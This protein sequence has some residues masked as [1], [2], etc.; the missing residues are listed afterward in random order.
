[1]AQRRS[2][3]R[4]FTHTARLLSDRIRR[5]GETRGFAVTRLLTHWED[6]V[7]AEIASLATPLDVSYARRGASGG[8]GATL[9]LLTTGAKAPLLEMQ[10]PKIK[11]RVNACYGYN[12]IARVRITQT[13]P[14]GFAEGQRSFGGAAAS[15]G[16]AAPPPEAFAQ[17]AEDMADVTDPG[18]RAALTQLGAHVLSKHEGSADHTPSQTSAPTVAQTATQTPAH[19]DA[20]APGSA[21]GQT[22]AKEPET[23]GSKPRLSRG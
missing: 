11:D 4:G 22:R 16:R 6:I 14:T 17:A 23:S 3:T 1:M 9:T 20:R 5:A 19:T 7:G 18:L 2:T 21:G 12:A 10:K 15:K 8:F 13:A